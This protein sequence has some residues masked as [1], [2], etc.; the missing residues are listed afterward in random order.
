MR[1]ADVAESGPRIT[2][3]GALP[4]RPTC[5]LAV[6]YLQEAHDETHQP[7]QIGL[8]HRGAFWTVAPF[9]G[10]LRRDWLSPMAY[11]F[12]LLAPLSELAVHGRDF[13][14]E[15]S[16]LPD[17]GQGGNRFFVWIRFRAAL[18]LAPS[19]GTSLGSVR[20]R[21]T[22][23]ASDSNYSNLCYSVGLTNLKHQ[24]ASGKRTICPPTS[25]FHWPYSFI[26]III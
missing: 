5:T 19:R 16:V 8:G 22:I 1:E 14:M 6:N 9:V 12:C 3:C 20:I 21:S 10:N 4:H 25:S 2:A 24:T 17:F 13:S 23:W 7:G 11:Q 15:H 26:I 18:E